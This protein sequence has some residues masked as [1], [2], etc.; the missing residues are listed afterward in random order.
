M[1]LVAT[2]LAV[3]ALTSRLELQNHD[4]TAKAVI[5]TLLLQDR[6]VR[7]ADVWPAKNAVV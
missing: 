1:L 7:A 3:G 4:G 2:S 6:F 5:E